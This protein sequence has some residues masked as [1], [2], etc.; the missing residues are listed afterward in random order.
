M[1]PLEYLQKAVNSSDTIDRIY[2]E[3]QKMANVLYQSMNQQGVI[4][5]SQGPTGMGKTLVE[6][7][8]A[9]A[10]KDDGKRV[11]IAV[12]TYNHVADNLRMEASLMYGRLCLPLHLSS[13]SRTCPISGTKITTMTWMGLVR[14]MIS[15]M[16]RI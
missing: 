14:W 11:L 1:N 9:C 10:L 3:Q 15:S 8:V 7:A 13:R 6:L 4:Q 12:P 16:Y 2:D 5:V